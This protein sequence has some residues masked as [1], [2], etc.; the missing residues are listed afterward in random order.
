[1]PASGGNAVP[2]TKSV[3]T[4]A[5]ESPDGAYLYYVDSMFEKPSPLWRVPVSGGVPF[6]VLDGVFLG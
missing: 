1:M 5:P 3:R 2:V 4:H 6:K